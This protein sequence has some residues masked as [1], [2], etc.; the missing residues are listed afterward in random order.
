VTPTPTLTPDQP[1]ANESNLS[2]HDVAFLKKAAKAGNKEIQVS[3][4]VMD[5]LTSPQFKQFAQTM[6]T[7]HT[8]VAAELATLA[9]SKG[10]KLPE[11]DTTVGDDWAKKTDDVDRRYIKEM[12]SDH[13]EA[14]KLFEK[15]SESKDA[16]IAAWAQKTLPTLQHH[17]S[18]A[19]DLEKSVE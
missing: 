17:L 4:A 6:V 18:M 15:A 9:A 16:D 2:H 12:V 5:H 8:A 7:D 11:P 14:V 19:L 1:A 13:K 10:V 3:Q